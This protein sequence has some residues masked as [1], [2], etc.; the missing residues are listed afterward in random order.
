MRYA[1]IHFLSMICFYEF[2][3]FLYSRCLFPVLMPYERE[4]WELRFICIPCLFFPFLFS[5]A[6]YRSR[7]KRSGGVTGRIL[8][9]VTTKLAGGVWHVL[10]DLLFWG[11][12]WFID[13][14]SSHALHATYHGDHNP[15][16]QLLCTLNLPGWSLTRRIMPKAIFSH[17]VPD[18]ECPA[19]LPKSCCP[20]PVL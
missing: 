19:C 20:M 7:L 5:S 9:R 6:A 13:I 16:G 2:I 17:L 8:H 1:L 11:L 14:P 3:D 18:I 10:Q 15:H 4:D 12:A